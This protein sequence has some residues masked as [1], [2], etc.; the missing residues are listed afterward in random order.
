MPH[1]V[2]RFERISLTLKFFAV[3]VIYLITFLSGCTIDNG[4]GV[5]LPDEEGSFLVY[6]RQSHIGEEKF[7]IE[8]TEDKVIIRSNQ[9]ENERGRISGVV[10]QLELTHDFTP[11]LYECVRVANNDTINILKVEVVGE[12]LKITEKHF[13]EISVP[14]TTTFFPLHSNIPAAMEIALYQYMLGTATSTILT[15]PRGEVTITEKGEDKVIVAGNE[16]TL[17]RLVVEGI[18]WGGR[19]VWVDQNNNLIALVKANTQI[20]EIIRKGYEEVMP[21]IIAGNVEEQMAALDGYTK[22]LQEARPQFTAL[23]GANLLDG[24]SNSIAENMVLLIKDDKIAGIGKHGELNIPETAR[25]I[26]LAGK[27]IMPGLWDMH[28]HSNQV[29]WAPA[30]LAGGI[31]A[32]RDNGNEIE[33]ATAFRDAIDNKDALGPEIFLAGMTDGPGAKGNGVIRARSAE[34]AVEVVQM[35]HDKGYDQLKIYTSIEPDMLKVLSEEA[36]KLDM[37]VVGHVPDLVGNGVLAVESGMDLLTHRGLILTSLFPNGGDMNYR[38]NYLLE[39]EVTQQQIDA[40]IE[41]F[42]E[43]NTVLDPTIALDVIRSMPYGDSI[44]SI[45]PDAHRIA[46][47]LFEGKRFRKGLRPAAAEKG[48]ANYTKAMNIIGQFHDAGIPIVAGTDNVV[49]VFSLYLEIESYHKLG[50]MSTLEAIQ[51][52]TIVPARVMKA[53]DRTGTLEVGKEADIAI[54]DKNPLDDISNIRTVEAVI[55]NGYYYQSNA[56]W[57]AADFKPRVN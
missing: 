23:V 15:Y 7:D 14:N 4:V 36:H 18:N 22:N 35:Y 3:S 32:I 1:S 19:S 39:N 46:Y 43:H 45:E 13:D 12:E 16:I 8:N 30:Y 49:P 57:Q 33:F 17:K 24:V 44:E 55:S 34:E 54:L 31:T 6:R 40:T 11:L 38:G 56:L 25:V 48:V 27:T 52:A 42:L 20:R 50:G 28:A 29:Q 2:F 53:A 47:E 21:T 51:A 26:D 10:A 37:P 41:F 5:N 9:T